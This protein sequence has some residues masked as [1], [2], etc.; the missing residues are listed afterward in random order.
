MQELF[1]TQ[2][3]PTPISS[4]EFFNVDSSG[5][6]FAVSKFNETHVVIQQKEVAVVPSFYSFP[7]CSFQER[8]NRSTNTCQQCL[9]GTVTLD[10]QARSCINCSTVIYQHIVGAFKRLKALEI[11][12][13]WIIENVPIVPEKE[14]IVSID[15]DIALK[16][17]ICILGCLAILLVSI[18]IKIICKK[19]RERAERNNRRKNEIQ[20]RR[21][22][23][24][25]AKTS[26]NKHLLIPQVFPAIENPNEREEC[27]AICQYK[28]DTNNNVT[29]TKCGHLFHFSCILSFSQ[30][31]K[32][33]GKPAVCPLCRKPIEVA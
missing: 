28:Y 9:E 30:R 1:F 23:K 10:F 31:E 2:A 22:S 24:K 11:C 14:E 13:E 20:L 32:S 33:Q 17:G 19:F 3:N 25:Q 21:I 26:K 6:Q 15:P 8:Y 29:V 18:V 12:G 4:D 5:E 27:C 16:I 7:V